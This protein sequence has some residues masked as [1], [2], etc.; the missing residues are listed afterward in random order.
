MSLLTNLRVTFAVVLLLSCGTAVAQDLHFTQFNAA[1]TSLNPSFTGGFGGDFRAVINHRKQWGVIGNGFQTY[2]FSADG[3][4]QK[5]EWKKGH[6]G[7]GLTAYKDVAGNSQFT[8]T[9][10]NIQFASLLYLNKNNTGAVGFSAGLGQKNMTPNDL[11]WDS[12]FDGVNY[13]SGLPANESTLFPSVGYFDFTAGASWT[14]GLTESTISSNDNFTVRIGA[15]YHH[16]SKPEISF[17]EDIPDG[18]FSK[19]AVTGD[20]HWGIKNTNFALRPKIHTFMQGPHREILAGLMVRSMLQEASHFTGLLKEMAISVGAYYRVGD[21]ISPA[22]ELE[23]AKFAFGFSY[24]LTISSLT[25]FNSG[26]GG[27]ELFIRFIN[28]NP[29]RSNRSE[30]TPMMN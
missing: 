3:A 21:A 5:K 24:D 22:L 11:Q 10:V 4:L 13:N 29:F 7:V 27:P 19:F 9:A 16:A 12:Q 2:G 18:L 6:L 25:E 26:R 20:M 15:A 23:V 8:T 30:G 17:S 1:P 14:Y 28:P